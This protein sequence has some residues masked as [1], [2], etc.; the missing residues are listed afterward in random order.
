MGKAINCNEKTGS[1]ANSQLIEDF[2]SLLP[3]TPQ[4]APQ[5]FYVYELAIE[6]IGTV[7][8]GKGV[9]F[10]AWDHCVNLKRIL[11]S[12]LSGKK[13]PTKTPLYFSMLNIMIKNS[14]SVE[15]K[16]I[17]D[18][19]SE[20]DAFLLEKELIHAHGRIIMG[21]G[22]LLNLADGGNSVG[23]GYFSARISH[24]EGANLRD[25]DSGN[26][27]R[28]GKR[29]RLHCQFSFGERGHDHGSA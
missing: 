17:K 21:D 24:A 13:S 29:E 6:K 19:L 4:V 3:Q 11:K 7:Y 15:V 28:P 8:I 14:R 16:I 18:G 5:G 20:T 9:K 1:I 25:R 26:R 22:D 2:N 12:S 27:T 23:S 10:R